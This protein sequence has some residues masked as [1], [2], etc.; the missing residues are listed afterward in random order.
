MGRQIQPGYVDMIIINNIRLLSS[1]RLL[2]TKDNMFPYCELKF[3]VVKI[4]RY[5]LDHGLVSHN[6]YGKSA[7]M[8]RLES[9]GIMV[10]TPQ[11][12]FLHLYRCYQFWERGENWNIQRKPMTFGKQTDNIFLTLESILGQ[13]QT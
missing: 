8:W 13:I 12:I 6:I 4:T 11:S 1:L 5:L 2:K 10:H 7:C 9:S 3:I